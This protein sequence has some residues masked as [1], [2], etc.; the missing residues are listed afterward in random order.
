MQHDFHISNGEARAYE[1]SPAY[2]QLCKLFWPGLIKV[3]LED[4]LERQRWGIDARLLMHNGYR[5]N[6]DNKIR[7]EVW[8]DVLIEHISDEERRIP[9]WICKRLYCNYILTIFKPLNKG[10]LIPRVPLQAVWA[11]LGVQWIQEFPEIRAQNRSKD[12]R[13]WITV[14]CALPIEILNEHVRGVQIAQ[15]TI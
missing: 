11:E 5:I 4:D 6:V 8:D 9:G 12:G 14:S 7:A 15:L 1:E 3:T 10:I 13:A 2:E